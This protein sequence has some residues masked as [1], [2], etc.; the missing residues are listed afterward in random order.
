MR[1]DKLIAGRKRFRGIPM[2][3]ILSDRAEAGGKVVDP[4][5]YKR[6]Y[7]NEIRQWIRESRIWCIDVSNPKGPE[8]GR[9]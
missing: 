9:K 5:A 2:L 4:E 1:V 6:E 3:M 8:P 7:A